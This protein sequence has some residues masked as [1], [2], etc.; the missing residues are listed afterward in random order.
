MG[1]LN[2]S[3]RHDA[4]NWLRRSFYGLLMAFLGAVIAA[5]CIFSILNANGLK[6]TVGRRTEAYVNDV[7]FQI[8]QNIDAQLSHVMQ[9]LEMLSDSLVRMGSNEDRMEFLKRKTP[10]LGFT[11]PVLCGLDGKGICTDGT[12]H[13]F[14]GLPG[15]EASVA[16]EHGVSFLDDQRILY[17]IPILYDGVVCGVLAGE[18]DKANMQALIETEGFEGN[19]VSCIIDRDGNVVIS[20]ADLD[21]FVALDDLFA[22]DEHPELTAAVEQMR[23]N[24]QKDIDGLIFFLPLRTRLT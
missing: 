1:H 18:R 24:M 7:A 5:V 23:A 21:F 17:T 8:T 13:D 19:S 3:A 4:R 10:M 9:D 15:F 6:N 2:T 14:S 11:Q 22:A 20:P 16:G 12:S